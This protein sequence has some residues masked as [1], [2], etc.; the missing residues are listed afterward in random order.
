MRSGARPGQV[1]R[2]C[3]QR[4]GPHRGVLLARPATDADAAHHLAVDLD[5]KAAHEHR[6]ATG[7]HGV[8]AEGFVWTALWYG[9]R[10][11][12]Y[13]PKGKLEREI[14]F[15]AKQTSSIT[16]GGPGLHEMY[17]T[18][19]ANSEPDPLQPPGYDVKMHRGGGLYRTKTEGVTGRPEFRSRVHFA[20]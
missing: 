5:R 18:T 12:R 15:P 4:G 3:F 14:F 9:G 6:E 11:Q 10:L 20:P 13:T 7:V 8:D 2:E 1:T 16:F 17:V 19:A